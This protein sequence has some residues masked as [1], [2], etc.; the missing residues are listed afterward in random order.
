MWIIFSLYCTGY[1]IA[2]VPCFRFFGYKACE[3]LPPQ[4]GTEPAPPA[5]EGNV[6]TAGPPGKYL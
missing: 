3:V 4:P 5:L 1:N 2:S 6:L